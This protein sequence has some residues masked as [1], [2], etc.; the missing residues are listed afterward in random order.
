MKVHDVI[1]GIPGI[2]VSDIDAAHTEAVNRGFDIVHPLTTEEWGV[3]R[4]FV[5]DPDGNVIN[6]TQHR[7]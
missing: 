4:F 6:I 2:P 1:P 5:R 3:T 7:E